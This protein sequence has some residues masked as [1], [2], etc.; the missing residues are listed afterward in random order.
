MGTARGADGAAKAD[1]D[2]EYWEDA[3][4]DA[5]YRESMIFSGQKQRLAVSEEQMERFRR[6]AVDG[7]G[8]RFK[9]A[10]NA[11]G[12]HAGAVDRKEGNRILYGDPMY[13]EKMARKY[14]GRQ[15]SEDH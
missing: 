10:G 13:D 9:A 4:Y 3:A 1:Q 14:F 8:S 5:R 15:C 12:G 2:E 11:E 7:K 6:I